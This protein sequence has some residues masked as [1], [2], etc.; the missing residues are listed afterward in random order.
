MPKGLNNKFVIKQ[1]KD[2]PSKIF[3][4]KRTKNTL[5]N[6]VGINMLYEVDPQYLTR[7]QRL[8]MNK[9]YLTQEQNEQTDYESF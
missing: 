8:L 9:G 3:I 1:P 2:F 4:K 7:Y 5:V 6:Y